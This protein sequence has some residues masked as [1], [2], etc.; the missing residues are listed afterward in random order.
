MQ[1]RGTKRKEEKRRV[2]KLN[3][4][5]RKYEGN[6]ESRGK[7]GEEARNLTK[8]K[9]KAGK[10]NRVKRKRKGKSLGIKSKEICEGNGESKKNKE[11]RKDLGLN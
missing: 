8:G 11:N 4:R 5:E 3:Q 9:R 6:W 1:E 2:R 10:R 7:E